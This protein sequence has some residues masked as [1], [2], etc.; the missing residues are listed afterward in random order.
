MAVLQ[1][2]KARWLYSPIQP[3]IN[4][5]TLFIFP[6]ESRI[7]A[8]RIFL[9]SPVILDIHVF[10]LSRLRLWN[11]KYLLF[12][13][14]L[15]VS[16]HLLRIWTCKD[17]YCRR[18]SEYKSVQTVYSYS[19]SVALFHNWSANPLIC[20]ETT[21]L[22]MVTHTGSDLWK[23]VP[24]AFVVVLARFPDWLTEMHVTS[25]KCK[26]G[27]ILFAWLGQWL[28]IWRSHIA[29]FA[30]YDT[31]WCVYGSHNDRDFVCY[32]LEQISKSFS[33]VSTSFKEES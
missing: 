30:V 27:A 7:I 23:F 22:L 1:H 15:V 12:F 10:L 31:S 5:C 28:T 9:K 29:I 13:V 25:S 16:G 18:I 21:L 24:M 11:N 17:Q 4:A 26:F 2:I 19:I 14:F 8:A 33:T 20:G 3:M 32:F 6:T